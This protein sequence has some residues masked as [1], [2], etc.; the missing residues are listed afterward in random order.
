MISC[1]SLSP[2]RTGKKARLSTA[3]TAGRGAAKAAATGAKTTGGKTGRKSTAAKA[4][5]RR[6]QQASDEGRCIYY[7]HTVYAHV[8]LVIY[9]PSQLIAQPADVSA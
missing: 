6:D 9:L 2:Q 7:V 1:I 4:S 8:T 3:T 5:K